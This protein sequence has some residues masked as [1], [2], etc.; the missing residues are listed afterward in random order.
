MNEEPNF[1]LLTE[2][3]LALLLRPDFSQDRR[4]F[5]DCLSMLQDLVAPLQAD[6]ERPQLGQFEEW[7]RA[8]EEKKTSLMLGE[9]RVKLS[10]NLAVARKLHLMAQ[11][12][13]FQDRRLAER[14]LTGLLQEYRRL[15]SW[16]RTLDR[17]ER[18][19]A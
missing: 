17:Y 7:E 8:F 12:P 6:P 11:A 10:D 18:V 4:V 15:Q 9:H 16:E 13:G 3:Q 2:H 19:S 14:Y 1:E 5:V